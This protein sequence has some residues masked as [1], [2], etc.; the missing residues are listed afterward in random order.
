MNTTAR[1]PLIVRLCNMVGDVVLGLPALQ[2]L[3]AEGYEL[4]L[5]GKGWA[6]P[7]LAGHGWQ[8]TGRAGS[9]GQR[10]EQLRRLRRQCRQ[11]DPGF[12]ARANTLLMPNS[13]SSAFEPRWAGLKPSGYARDGRRL[14][15]N[16]AW[17]P[18]PPAHSLEG[19]SLRSRL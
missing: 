18:D 1:R 13:F 8:C 16:Q 11:I 4:H 14:L 15:L 17:Q 2:W 7:L 19:F 5:F 10:I 3:E 12:D 9:L 6:K